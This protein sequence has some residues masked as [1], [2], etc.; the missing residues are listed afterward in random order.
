MRFEATLC[1]LGLDIHFG[2]LFSG[3]GQLR[4]ERVEDLLSLLPL[5]V[6]VGGLYRQ[7]LEF[8]RRSLESRSGPVGFG[9]QGN[10]TSG[11]HRPELAFEIAFQFLVPLRFRCLPLQ[12]IDLPGDLFQDVEHA[13][14]VL[15]RAFELCFSQTPPALVLRDAR[16][17]FN[18]RT[19][20]L[21]FGRKDLPDAALLD[22]RVALRAEAAPHENILNIAQPGLPTVDQIFAFAGTKQAARD[23]DLAGFRRCLRDLL[24]FG[25]F[26]TGGRAFRRPPGQGGGVGST[27]TIVT[28][29]I[30]T[31]FRDFVPAKITS[32]I[33]APRRLRADCSPNTQ[34]M[35]S[36]RFDF[37]HPFG[38]TTAAIPPP[39]NRN[40]VRSQNDLN[41]W[42]ST[43]LSFSK[44]A[45]RFLLQRHHTTLGSEQSKVATTLHNVFSSRLPQHLGVWWSI[46]QRR[47]RRFWACVG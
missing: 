39:L 7:I 37:P 22:N 23:R 35:A 31:G 20:V 3:F 46:M 43:F 36:L 41:P 33:R 26:I 24:N 21:G 12:R 28:E 2:E 27:R 9:L 34:L 6:S 15:F 42:S 38:P 16:R 8:G 32:S 29:A 4:F 11:E 18:H 1:A 47:R 25:H 40:S 30:P 45:P 14:E 17:L 10:M 13:G 5:S 44:A 19:P